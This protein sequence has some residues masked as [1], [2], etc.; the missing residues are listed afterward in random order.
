MS[1]YSG[2]AWRRRINMPKDAKNPLKRITTSIENVQRELK[3]LRPKVIKEDQK[4]IDLHLSA[5]RLFGQIMEC[6]VFCKRSKGIPTLGLG[7]TLKGK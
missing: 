1:R 6:E 7:F 2:S 4:R 3:K 5:L